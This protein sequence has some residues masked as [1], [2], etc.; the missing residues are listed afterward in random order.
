MIFRIISG[1]FSARFWR[2]YASWA[3]TKLEWHEWAS[4]SDA[5]LGMGGEGVKGER[6]TFAP[7]DI[8]WLHWAVHKFA[9]ITVD[10][11]KRWK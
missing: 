3:P 10:P 1:E 5:Y 7:Q 4:I 11:I 9:T 2:Q 8:R 6:Y